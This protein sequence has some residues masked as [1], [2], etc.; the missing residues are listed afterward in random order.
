MLADIV[1]EVVL[2]LQHIIRDKKVKIINKLDEDHIIYC[3]ED[4]YKQVIMNLIG[5]AV[6]AVSVGGEITATSEM[7]EKETIL[8]IRDNGQ[9]IDEDMLSRLFMPFQTTKAKGTGLGLSISYK[10]IKAHNGD[11]TAESNGE[12]YTM[13]TISVPTAEY[14]KKMGE[15]NGE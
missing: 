13:F 3:D 1:D 8:H 6:D 15:E 10:I 7:T 11:I 12:N 14:A 5:N 9:G 2:Y 4:M